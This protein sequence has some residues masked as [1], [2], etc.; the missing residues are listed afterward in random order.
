MPFCVVYSN[1]MI[2]PKNGFAL[3]LFLHLPPLF[4][5]FKQ[6]LD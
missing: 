1:K 5:L 3:I 2:D 4:Q 6:H